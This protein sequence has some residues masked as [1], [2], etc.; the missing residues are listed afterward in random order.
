MPLEQDKQG[1]FKFGLT[2][3]LKTGVYKSVFSRA[4][5]L[6]VE[7]DN[8]VFT[9]F[10]VAKAPGWQQVYD[11]TNGDPI[12]GVLPIN[13]GGERYVYFGDLDTLY[14]ANVDTGVGETLGSG[15]FLPRDAGGAI[16]DSGD[17]TWDGGSTVFDDGRIMAGHWSMVTYGAFILAANGFDS[18]VIR[19]GLGQFVDM[20]G[21]VTGIFVSAPGTG[22]V[23][24]DILTLTGG[25]GTGAT[26]R[27][28]SVGASGEIFT[29]GMETGG[30]GY[31]TAPTGFTG[32]TGTSATF[33][34][35]VCDMDVDSVKIF[36]KRGPHI[37]GFN[38]SA[39]GREFI[40]SDA[41]DPD[42]WVTT[43]TNLA[44]A[45]E[46][47]ELN[48]EIVAVAPLGS[49]L[50]VYGTDQM[51]L[52]NYLGNDLVFGY[53]PAL[54]DVGAVSAHAVVAVGPRNFGL[55]QQGF[56]VTDGA[57]Y[58][59]IDKEIR[60]WV[61]Q[62]AAAG[63]LSKATAFHDEAN[64]Q[65]RWYF[66]TESVVI[67]EGVTYNYELGVWAFVTGDRSA[68]VGRDVL[69]TPVTG[70]EGGL[71]L[72]ENSGVNGGSTAIEALLTSKPLDLGN[73]DRVKELSSL[74]VGHVG[75][76]LTY[77]VG[78]SE[79]EN[80][81]PVY[82]DWVPLERGFEFQNLRTAGRWLRLGFRSATLNADWEIMSLEIQGRAE[83]TR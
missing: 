74:R 57:S 38:T 11:T 32:G 27:V 7:G 23:V 68:C 66:P 13:E 69:P 54:S 29:V 35:T 1:G 53:Q 2:E 75:T 22:Y 76:G 73:A 21:G 51:F 39:N 16:W 43:A 78:W 81:T 67:A 59:Y 56:F 70:T 20:V 9:Q 24:D 79:T 62:N 6:W 80:G 45:L 25:S 55:S 12:R 47:R 14:R 34:F 17:S 50:A 18:P 31:T 44:G 65:V 48:S 10:G 4:V 52:V 3:E 8:V 41:D 77:R 82:T 5:P 30:T 83:G 61:E 15:Y 71:L 42:T 46:I 40:W 58:Q 60:P 72:F 37:L 19:K 63:Q 33:T 64:K 26:A 28:L 36:A 49:R